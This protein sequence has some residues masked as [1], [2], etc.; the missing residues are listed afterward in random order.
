MEALS[1]YFP[2]VD[3]LPALLPA[4]LTNLSLPIYSR[5]QPSL[6]QQY[7][8]TTSALMTNS[9]TCLANILIDF[10]QPIVQSPTLSHTLLLNQTYSHLLSKE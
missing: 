5:L 6:H 10:C 1:E 8:H 2:P 9:R 7:C 4:P 3:L